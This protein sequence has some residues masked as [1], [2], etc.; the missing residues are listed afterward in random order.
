MK[1][2]KI[3]FILFLSLLFLMSSEIFAQWD[4]RASM[5]LNFV[6]MPGLRDYLNQNYAMQNQLSTFSSAIEFGTEAGYLLNDKYQL[7]AEIAYEFNSFTYPSLG[8]N[9]E[10]DYSLLMPSVTGYYVLKGTGYRFKFGGGLGPRFAFVAQ[11]TG[12]SNQKQNFS[13][14]GFGVLL[15]IDGNTA[16]TNNIYAYIA[17][18]IRY[19][20]NGTPKNSNNQ[21]IITNANNDKLNL[22][23]LSCGVKL[24]ISYIF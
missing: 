2:N 4:I 18:D 7:G 16:L 13:S 8:S 9:F 11:S 22:N 1:M 14:T 20:I 21:P 10:F 23:S 3:N 15:K 24:G 12:V 17:G 5:G 6:D 19:D